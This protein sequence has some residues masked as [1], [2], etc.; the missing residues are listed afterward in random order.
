MST[1]AL[2]YEDL[3]EYEGGCSYFVPNEET[4]AWNE[5][6]DHH[7]V[8]V[9]YSAGICSGGEIG[10]LNLL[11]RTQRELIL[12]DHSSK[13]LAG[14][15]IKWLLFKEL[16]FERAKKVLT[17]KDTSM[18]LKAIDEV[19]ENLPK[20]LQDA[21]QKVLY[22]VGYYEDWADYSKDRMINRLAQAWTPASESVVR[23]LG[24]VK[25]VHGDLTDLASKGKFGLLYLSNAMDIWHPSRLGGAAQGI[26]IA[27][28]A[29][30]GTLIMECG[31]RDDKRGRNVPWTLLEAI[32]KT[33]SMTWEYRLWRA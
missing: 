5:L 22:P 26:E 33:D 1:L 31:H 12:V 16:G 13:S 24:K 4:S 23:K 14:A 15:T 19:K 29:H 27:K 3:H 21:L 20:S 8:N 30:K 7:G 17:C 10:F 9:H 11:P 18:L 28:C 2:S 32:T 25:F 6:L